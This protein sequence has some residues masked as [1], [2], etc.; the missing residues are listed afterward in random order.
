MKKL[1]SL[2]LLL[3]IYCSAQDSDMQKQLPFDSKV[4]YGTLPNGMKYFVRYNAKPEKRAELRLAV[5]AGSTAEDDDQQGL[6]HFTEHMAFNGSAHFKK[7]ELVDYLEGVGTKFGP[8]LNAYT[9]FDET[10]Y[11]LQVP[12]DSETILN[13]GFL[14]LQDWASGL[15]FDQ[16]E[17][18]KERGVVVEE[19]RLGQG[20]QE[21]MR[22][23]YWPYL[24]AG[25]RYAERL[26]IGQKEIIET[27]PRDVSYRFYKDWYRPDLMAVIAVGDFDVDKIEML[28]KKQFST[29]PSSTSPRPLRVWE[30]PDQQKMSV[31]T[32]TDKETPYTVIQMIYKQPVSHATTEGDYRKSILNNLY[33]SM[34]GSR[35]NEISKQPDAPFLFAG[36][37]YE[38]LVR[39]KNGYIGYAVT[40]GDGIVK[41]LSSIVTENE[42]VKRHGFTQ[43][44]LDRT[45]KEVMR[46]MESAYA[47]RDKSESRNYV[48]EYVNYFL[49]QEPSPGIEF[50]Y[51]LYKK[52]MDG[53]QLSE[54]NE[55]PKKWLKNPDNLVL[56][57]MAPEKEDVKI[58]DNTV[59]EETVKKAMAADVKPYE[60]KKLAEKLMETKPGA[61]KVVEE[62]V[63]KE[64]NI[65]KWKLAN[66]ATVYLKPTDFKN[67]EIMFTGFSWGGESML[68]DKD[69]MSAEMAASIADEGGIASF[70]KIS[71]DKMMQGKIAEVNASIDSYNES[72]D[73]HCSPADLETMLQLLYLKMTNPRKDS[74]SYATLMSQQKA[75]LENAGLAPEQAFRD[76]VSYVMGNYNFRSK[77]MSVDRLNEVDLNRAISIY[78][79]R[80]GDASDFTFTFVG[81]FKTDE[82]KSLIETYIGGM[83]STY[84]KES[85]KDDGVRMPAGRVER[86]VLRGTE[87]KSSVAMKFTGAFEYNRKNRF[88]VNAML[89]LL[90]IKLRE[91]LREEKGG[92]YGV[93]AY[94]SMKKNPVS[95][96]EI[97]IGFGCAPT[98]VK[99]LMDAS[100]QEIE[101]IKKNGCD[102][103]NLTKVKETFIRERETY[104]KENSF[105][106]SAISSS[107]NYGEDINEITQY[108]SWV[109]ALKSNDFKRLANQYFD[110]KNYASFVLNPETK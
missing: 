8:H 22:R 89:K 17:V 50:E 96:Y 42:R 77:P 87:P 7:N 47:D 48:S 34:M 64:L 6:A 37:A 16:T 107:A 81:N 103:K 45:K 40:K 43:S 92:V 75:L 18:D 76:T 29:I 59:L 35:L 100:L 21:R 2:F 83:P 72:V 78:K 55:L 60:E 62:T 70:D 67:D 28:I 13:N 3:S 32:V 41:G 38:N 108:N 12:T 9:S 11:M 56:M 63:N 69:F 57:V 94:P 46:G 102:D 36:V 90:S 15:S 19:W 58:P 86:T 84:R 4:R 61:G 79:K 53:I 25:S 104:L 24:F 52:Y 1:L 65:T 68:E 51:Q 49:E 106:L 23:K 66:G 54:L 31:V 97:T 99:I 109:N 82:I 88:E 74:S 110:M 71:L 5:N 44:E 10:V 26:P 101:G 20:A 30:V 14:I 33:N 39:N 85:A 98:N 95:T 105:W 80:F 91:N 27:A 73:G 93:G